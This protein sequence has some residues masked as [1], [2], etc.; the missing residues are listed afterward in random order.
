MLPPFSPACASPVLADVPSEATFGIILSSLL[1]PQIV[2]GLLFIILAIL[3]FL[4]HPDQLGDTPVG[5]EAYGTRIAYTSEQITALLEPSVSGNSEEGTVV[6]T[7][8]SF[9]FWLLQKY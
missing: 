2:L 9:S 4:S 1:Q 6:P 7:P 8:A 3:W 5:S